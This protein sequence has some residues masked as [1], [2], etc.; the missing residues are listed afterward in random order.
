MSDQAYKSFYS[1][2][3]FILVF[4]IF[5]FYGKRIKED[6]IFQRDQK[7]RKE[8]ILEQAKLQH[9]KHII[10]LENFLFCTTDKFC[11]ASHIFSIPN[12]LI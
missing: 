6:K 10:F 7:L 5:N 8:K 9:E 1:L 2:F 4:S 3:I 11:E 12:K